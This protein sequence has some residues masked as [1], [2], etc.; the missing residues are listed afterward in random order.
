MNFIIK[1]VNNFIVYIEKI[2]LCALKYFFIH[3]F[4]F[5]F[6]FMI[7]LFKSNRLLLLS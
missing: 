2:D 1:L 4:T 6:M 7:N 3:Q 5:L